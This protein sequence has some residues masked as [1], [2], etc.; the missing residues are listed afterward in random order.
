MLTMDAMEH[1]FRNL[2]KI[3]WWNG[4]DWLIDRSKWRQ[5]TEKFNE[6]QTIAEEE[7]KQNSELVLMALGEEIMNGT[8]CCR[9]AH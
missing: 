4:A 8:Y 1:L 2:K 7:L 3:E 9:K 5:K 6:A